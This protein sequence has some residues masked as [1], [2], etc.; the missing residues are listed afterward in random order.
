MRKDMKIWNYFRRYKCWPMAVS[1][2]C[3][4]DI[5]LQIQRANQV[6]C[7]ISSLKP[8]P[9]IMK[10]RSNRDLGKI[11]VRSLADCRDEHKLWWPHTRNTYFTKIV[12]KSHK[13]TP[14]HNNSSKISNPWGMRELNFQSY[15]NIMLKIFSSQ[16]KYRTCKETGKYGTFTEGKKND[17]TETIPG[18]T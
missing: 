7:T 8:R 2:T 15:H 16:K 4:K 6:S 13:Q 11:F 3:L 9:I 12:Q 18:E 14:A 10:F 5:S 17:L 1:E